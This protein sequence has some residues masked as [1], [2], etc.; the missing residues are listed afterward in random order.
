[1]CPGRHAR[2]PLI[3][4]HACTPCASV[5]TMRLCVLRGC[6]GW[7]GLTLPWSLGL[8]CTGSPQE[9]AAE[10]IEMCPTKH[11]AFQHLQPVDVAF[12]RAIAPWH[13]HPGFDRR[14]VVA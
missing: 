12:A 11:L 1:M 7:G 3:I 8:S 14:S 4:S 6:T 13:G 2:P 10:E 5:W 9:A